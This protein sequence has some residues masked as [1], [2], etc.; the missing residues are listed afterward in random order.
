MPK[1][2]AFD[3]K[4][5]EYVEV[6]DEPIHRR[7]FSNDYVYIYIAG[8][9]QVLHQP[10]WPPAAVQ[11]AHK[12]EFLHAGGVGFVLTSTERNRARRT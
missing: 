1:V 12:A 6:H 7:Q 3:G 4:L 11:R 9:R 2:A 8:F 10:A 5:V